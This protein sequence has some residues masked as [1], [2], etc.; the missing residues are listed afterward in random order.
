MMLKF[1]PG[2]PLGGT[3]AT[4]ASMPTLETNVPTLTDTID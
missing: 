3:Q 1:G 2:F 4:Q